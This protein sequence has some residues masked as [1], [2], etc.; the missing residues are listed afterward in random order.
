MDLPGFSTRAGGLPMSSEYALVVEN[1]SKCYQ[2]YNSPLDRLFQLFNYQRKEAYKEHWAVKNVS[3]GIKR[4]ETVGIVGRNGSGKSTFLQLVCGTLF[5]TSG[6]IISQGRIAALLELGAGFNPEFTG[7]ENVYLNGALLGFSKEEIDELYPEIIAFADIGDFVD[8]PIKVYSSGMVVRLA[9]A[10]AISADPQILVIDEAL[11]VGDERFQRKCF[12][13]IQEIKESGATILFV[14]HSGGAVMQLCDRAML[15]DDGELLAL[16]EPKTIVGNYQKLLYAP[17]DSRAMIK[18]ELRKEL[19]ADCQGE[20]SKSNKVPF[21]DVEQK[22]GSEKKD[23][24]G[25]AYDPNLKPDSTMV[26]VSQGAIIEDVEIKTQGGEI[27]NHLVR[28][29]SYLYRYKVKF[30]QK[31]SY[32]RFGMMIKT[33][34]GAELG[35]AVSAPNPFSGL[36]EVEQGETIQVEFEFKAMLNADSYFMNAG[37]TAMT[38]EG[39]VYLYRIIDAC[40]FRVVPE[41]QP[42]AT[43]VIDFNAICNTEIV[44]I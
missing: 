22:D 11:S 33:V 35:G 4:G 23:G 26:Y 39:E 28:G 7:R 12:S 19:A 13:R 42:T 3:V 24:P 27:V 10:V 8:Q 36:G 37:V 16:G 17:D 15:L 25:E 32:V 18:A 20:C 40:L 38:E 21:T 2:I 6:E 41:F 30:D 31:A 29:R 9:F 34:S 44:G 14:S 5:P 1:L 43:G